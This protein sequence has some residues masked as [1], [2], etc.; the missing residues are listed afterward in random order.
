MN[1]FPIA[2]DS[3]SSPLR[4]ASLRL[5]DGQGCLGLT[6][7]PGKKDSDKWNRD[8]EEDLR[9]IRNWGAST[10]VTLME[11]HELDLLKVSH[12][13]ERVQ[14]LGM[15]WIHLPIRDVDVP[16]QRFERGWSIAGPEIHDRLREGEKIVIHCRGGL[17]RTGVVAGLILVERGCAPRDAV[18]Q[19]RSARPGAIETVKQ[20]KY[21]LKAKALTLGGSHE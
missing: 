18:R 20:E 10:V 1:R 14:K 11:P 2:Q 15:R 17:G 5:G 3:V 16:D 8:L 4:I 6:I 7:C 13:G 12:L 19:V 9:A 21:V